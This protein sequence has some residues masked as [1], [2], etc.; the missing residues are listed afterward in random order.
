MFSIFSSGY[1]GESLKVVCWTKQLNNSLIPGRTISVSY[2]MVEESKYLALEKKKKKE[3]T[4]AHESK[5][6]KKVSFLALFMFSLALSQEK[7][8][9]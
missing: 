2:E 7:P 8:E 9:N 5:L 4:A 3:Q 1:P 6:K